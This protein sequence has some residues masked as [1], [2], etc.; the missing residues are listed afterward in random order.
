MSCGQD[1]TK[2]AAYLDGE[3]LRQTMRNRCSSI[4]AAARN[5]R[6]KLLPW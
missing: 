3:N 1:R 5:A 2:L 4:F 6:L